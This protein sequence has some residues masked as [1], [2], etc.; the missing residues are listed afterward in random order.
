M[1]RAGSGGPAHPAVVDAVREQRFPDHL[2]PEAGEKRF[3]KEFPILEQDAVIGRVAGDPPEGFPPPERISIAKGFAASAGP[4]GTAERRLASFEEADGA[5]H[6]V[7]SAS[8]SSV[9]QCLDEHWTS[10]V[11]VVHGKNE[12]AF[13]LASGPVPGG[14][15]LDIGL[16]HDLRDGLRKL[17]FDLVGK[18]RRL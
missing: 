17:R 11:V 2:Q 18:G 12:F 3:G 15:Q 7:W 13:G 6:H 8:E 4:H 1:I 10:E 5:R 9:H 16:G 14:S